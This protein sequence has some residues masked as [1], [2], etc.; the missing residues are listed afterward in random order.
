MIKIIRQL[1]LFLDP[2]EKINKLV[3]A[4]IIFV[5]AVGA[6]GG[7]GEAVKTIDVRV[8]EDPPLLLDIT[9]VKVVFERRIVS[10]FRS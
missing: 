9:S 2:G 7:V 4:T 8:Y 5:V 10:M 6:V 1:E 3:L